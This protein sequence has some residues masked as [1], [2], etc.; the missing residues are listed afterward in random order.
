MTSVFI[1]GGTGFVGGQI[2]EALK[3]RKAFSLTMAVRRAD[4]VSLGG[5]VGIV[6]LPDLADPSAWRFSLQGVDVVIHA[7]ARVH[8]MR[9]RSSDPLDDYRRA[10]VNGTMNLARRAAEA[11]VK[12]FIY[13][14]SVKVNGERTLQSAPFLPDGNFHPVD[15]YGISKWEAEQALMDLSRKTQMEVVIVRPVLVYGPG[16]KANFLS[17]M[18]WLQKGIPLPLGAI[19]NK[20]SLVALDNLVD[21]I[22]TCIEHPAAA[23]ETFLVSDGED[24]STTELLQRMA[25]ALNMPAR[26]LP[27]P[28]V[29]LKCSA[30]LLGKSI[31]AQRLCDSLQVDISKNRELLGWY[32]PVSVDDA[33]KKTASHFLEKL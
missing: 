32:P 10:N 6:S 29:L 18:R 11:G 26:L 17:M 9:D 15:P 19:N 27:I 13:V 2:V 4:S 1:T 5:G 3:K 16:V 7:A 22:I 30:G 21:F 33:L 8:V 12:R 20:R 14:S 23:H 25:A 24:L 31:I 28:P